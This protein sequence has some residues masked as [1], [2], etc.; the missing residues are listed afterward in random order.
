M[1]FFKC[2]TPM[3]L[4]L[5]VLACMKGGTQQIDL[6]VFIY[7]GVSFDIIN[8][9]KCGL[10]LQNERQKLVGGEQLLSKRSEGQVFPCM[11]SVAHLETP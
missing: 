7:F 3:L 2:L 9:L 4:F 1:Q 10:K 6:S 11:Q 8:M 5:F